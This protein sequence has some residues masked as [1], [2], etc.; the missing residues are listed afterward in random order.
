MVSR[1]NWNEQSIKEH[2]LKMINWFLATFPLPDNFKDK[3][4]WNTQTIE[5]TLFSPLDTDA[6]DIAEG[7]KPVE[8][9]IFDDILKVNTWQDVFIKFL[10]YLKEKPKYDF[11]YILDNQIEIFKREE[12]ILKWSSLKE[13]VDSNLD[14]TSRYK[15][16]DGK[17]WDRVKELNDDLLFIHINISALICM[18]RIAT[19]MEKL[20]M[21]DNSIKIKLNENGKRGKTQAFSTRA[22]ELFN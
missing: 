6:G 13:L 16:F 19:V 14:L 18:S 8:L 10:K 11:E 2:Q 1:N 17:N 20:F 12:T 4:N 15:T 3:A 21:P 7:N 5:N 22:G 9:Q